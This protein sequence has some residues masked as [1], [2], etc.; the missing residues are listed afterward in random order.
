MRSCCSD[1]FLSLPAGLH[2]ATREEVHS[3]SK[4]RRGGPGVSPPRF[5]QGGALLVEG[6]RA[7]DGHW[8][9]CACLYHQRP[10][11]GALTG[12][13]CRVQPPY[14]QTGWV[15]FFL[16]RQK[17]RCQFFLKHTP[18]LVLDV[19]MAQSLTYLNKMKCTMWFTSKVNRIHGPAALQDTQSDEGVAE[20]G[21]WMLLV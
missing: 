2:P 10:L 21:G 14:I 17:N 5:A 6:G 13:R 8:E 3:D 11:K 16:A 7:A 18:C 1:L 9:V 4:R 19:S 20:K 15:L 12:L